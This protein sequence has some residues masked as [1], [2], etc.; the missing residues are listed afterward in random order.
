[1]AMGIK[2]TALTMM[3]IV[4]FSFCDILMVCAFVCALQIRYFSS[5]QIKIIAVACGIGMCAQA[6]LA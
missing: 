6:A 2:T 1:M 4:T 5:Q 3:T